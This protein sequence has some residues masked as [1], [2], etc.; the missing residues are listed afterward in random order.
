MYPE[1]QFA[2]I[3]DDTQGDLNAFGNIVK[4]DS[5]RIAAVFIRTASDAM[6]DDEI[7]AKELIEQAGVPLWLGPDYA[8]G[9]D[10]LRATGLA[11]DKD[12]TQIIEVIEETDGAAT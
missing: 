3:G 9:Q 2:L 6:S 11:S 4:D 8:T 1:M 12:A 5:S 7:A 10:F